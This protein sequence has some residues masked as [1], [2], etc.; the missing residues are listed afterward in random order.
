MIVRSRGGASVDVR[1][2]EFGSSAIP[3][4]SQ[5]ALSWSGVNVT[6]DAAQGLP[7][8][9]A[10]V[11]LVS[12]TIASLPLTV[13]DGEQ[14]AVG[15]DAW[16][17]LMESPTSDLDPFAWMIQIAGSIETWGNA[18]CQIVRGRGRVLELIPLDPSH[19][20]VRRDRDDK[21]KRFDI[22]GP[23]GGTRNLTTDDILH[24]PGW[25]PAGGV[26]GLSPIAA[27]RD[28][29]GGGLAMQRFQNAYWRNDAAPGMVIK[30]PGNLTQQQAQEVLRVWNQSHAGLYNAHKPAVLA[31]GAE[32]DRIPV[33]LEDA[34][35]VAQARMSVEDVARIWRV[36]PHMIGSGDP[37]GTTAEQESLRFLA[38]SLLPRIRRIEQG[39]SH[40]LPELFG[41][42]TPLRPEFDATALLRADTPTRTAMITA[43][44]QGGWL[45]INDARRMEGLPPIPDGDQVQQTPVG[46]AP[47]L[48]PQAGASAGS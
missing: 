37:T 29:I 40:G 46:G 25:V 23:D 10:A 47:N 3:W 17:L 34:A 32:L 19:I 28:S 7:A 24:I 35:F 9:S 8:V 21:R 36:P 1:A 6:P 48:Q 45:S 18:Y 11:R 41:A 42:A 5:S 44:R 20:T 2:G 14:Q 12:E 16:A 4:P 38:F 13:R 39:I 27:H 22:S 31:G 30:V 26:A 15:T 43:G 33:N